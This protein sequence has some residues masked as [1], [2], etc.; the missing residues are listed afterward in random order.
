MIRQGDNKN[1]SLAPIELHNEIWR[2]LQALA[3]PSSTD[4]SNPTTSLAIHAY[5]NPT[6]GVLRIDTEPNELLLQLFNAE[7]QLL[8]TK[9]NSNEL[10]V[11]QLPTG[12]YQLR[13]TKGG[14]TDLFTAGGH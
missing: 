14:G 5:P 2:R 13:I 8:I 12:L 4:Q 3:L 7:G 9:Q 10:A 11:S 1:S 6:K